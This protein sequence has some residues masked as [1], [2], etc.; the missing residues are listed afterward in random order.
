VIWGSS[1]WLE[2]GKEGDWEVD[3]RFVDEQ[4]E[5]DKEE[6]E[7]EEAEGIVID[8]KEEEEDTDKGEG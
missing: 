1:V 3:N 7:E 4:E 6:E 5:D 8:D 2:G